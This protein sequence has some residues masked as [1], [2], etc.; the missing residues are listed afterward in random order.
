MTGNDTLG[1]IRFWSIEAP[2][3]TYDG[4][5]AWFVFD[6][7]GGIPGSIVDSGTVQPIE[8]ILQAGVLGFYD[9]YVYDLD[10]ADVALNGS[11]AYWLGLHVNVGYGTR[12]DIY[13][14]TGGGDGPR[15]RW[16]HDGQLVR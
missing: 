15:E 6:H 14:E 3:T 1:W 4:N 13:W 10:I 2:G 7:N 12:W 16:R 5:V 8:D 9:E 11:T